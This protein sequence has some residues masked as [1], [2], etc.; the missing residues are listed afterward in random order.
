MER[1]I[2]HLDVN[3]AFLSWEAVRHLSHTG[4]DLRLIPSAIGGNPEKR[5]GIILAKSIPAKKMGIKT[6]EPVSMA[7]RKCPELV[8]HPPDFHLYQRNSNAFMRICH[9][10]APVIEKFSIDECFMDMT[11]TGLLYPDPVALACEIKDKIRTELGFTV[12][13]GIA[14]NKLCAKMASDFEKP[15]RVHTLFR[16]EIP[17]KL[18]TL[19]VD[20][21]F[22][23]GR[24]TVEKLRKI[25][26]RTIGQLAA[27]DATSLQALF[28][29]K[30]G[31]SLHA[32]ARGEDDSPVLAVPEE[33]KGYSISTTLEE[34]VTA[35]EDAR[36]ILLAL[37]DSVAARM[38]ADGART[39]CVAV[40][41]RANDFKNHSHQQSLS[42]PTDGTME[43]YDIS[44]R[45]FDALWDKN[46]PLRL[47]GIS[48]T[49]LSREEGGQLTFFNDAKREKEE[50]IDKTV[51]G[52]R[53]R[54]GTGA[55]VR[56]A[57]YKT[58]LNVGRKYKAQLESKKETR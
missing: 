17:Q 1:L 57:V 37:A 6:G 50:K 22:M 49:Q 58:P 20:E 29:Q 10:Y 34:D 54:F 28:G 2:F 36:R 48:L 21:L 3:S 9:A 5:T 39:A 14:N 46:T 55:V 15:D 42:A 26:I 31:S 13:I 4:E 24:A 44:C 35:S 11:G 27:M 30:H 41:I 45:L 16:H 52:I 38:R 43:I 8:L 40:T 47:L 25:N 23:T 18:W 7:L 32:R 56:G 12:N 51:D 33:A 19:P 53:A